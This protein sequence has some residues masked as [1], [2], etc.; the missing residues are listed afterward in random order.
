ME[1]TGLS[2]KVDVNLRHDNRNKRLSFTGVSCL[3]D[4]TTVRRLAKLTI[5][6]TRSYSNRIQITQDNHGI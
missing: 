1:H 5:Y 3:D 2:E 6:K 4:S